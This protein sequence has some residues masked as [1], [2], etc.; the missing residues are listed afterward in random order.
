MPSMMCRRADA[1]CGSVDASEALIRRF[2]TQ[3][4]L[5]NPLPRTILAGVTEVAHESRPQRSEFG[6][7]RAI[8]RVSPRRTGVGIFNW[9]IELTVRE[10]VA[11]AIDAIV[12][13]IAPGEARFQEFAAKKIVNQ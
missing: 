4:R 8:F 2:G 11:N 1:Q 3:T 5:S 6:T 13:M 12:K 10:V 7:C 9:S